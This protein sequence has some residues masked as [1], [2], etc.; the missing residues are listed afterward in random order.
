MPGLQPEPITLTETEFSELE[1]LV[2]KHS[3]PQQIA[4]R[5]RIILLAADGKNNQEIGRELNISRYM[6]RH[7]RRR[8]LVEC[9]KSN[10]RYSTNKSIHPPLKIMPCPRP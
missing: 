9:L 2:N 8:W 6:V 10:F 7:W 1:K 3:T 4:L 5:S